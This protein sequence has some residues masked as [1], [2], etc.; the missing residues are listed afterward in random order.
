MDD[1]I[2]LII[3]LKVLSLLT[4]MVLILSIISQTFPH[5]VLIDARG[6]I[7]LVDRLFENW[8]MYCDVNPGGTYVYKRIPDNMLISFDADPLSKLGPWFRIRSDPGPNPGKSGTARQSQR[9]R[10]P[11]AGQ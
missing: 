8:H 3:Y 1:I 4:R 7:K 2:L 5:G 6:P 11:S 9:I 10:N